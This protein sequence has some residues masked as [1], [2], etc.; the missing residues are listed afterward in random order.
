MTIFILSVSDQIYS[1]QRIYKE[2]TRRGH[3]VR[4]INHL[5]CT[6]KLANG[7]AEIHYNGENIIDIPDV[8]IPRIGASATRHG[9]AI[10]KQFELSGVYSTVTSMGILQAQNKVRTLQIM[11]QNNIAIPNTIFSVNPDT[12]DE[13]INL[14]GGAPIIIKLQEGTHGS[15]VILA[16]SN[17]SAKSIIDTMYA[18]NANILLQEF[19]AES[20]SEDIRAFVVNNKVVSAMKRKGAAGDFRSNIHQGGSGFKISLS[21]EEKEIAI[22]ASQYLNLPVAGVDLIRSKRGALLIE[23]NTAPGLQGIE[24]YTNQNIAKMIIKFLEDDVYTKL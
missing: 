10:V 15:G 5:K 17:Q 9:A 16:E 12:I 3:N 19:I 2:A 24:N 7:K 20:N 4:I 22:K 1:T 11:N 8:I 6:V 23:V 13:Q 18:T 21:E 14:L